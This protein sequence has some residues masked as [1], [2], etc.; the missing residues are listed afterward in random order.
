MNG[1]VRVKLPAAPEYGRMARTAAIQ[2]ARR[3]GFT[4]GD[5]SDLRLTMDAAVALLIDPD[6]SDGS[7]VFDYRGKAG[8][9]IIEAHIEREASTPIPHERI[10]RFEATA[11][12]LVDSWKL[13][14]DEN[15]LWLQKSGRNCS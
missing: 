15:Y 3:L 6:Q 13:D 2:I 4:T 5:I 10:D 8:I 12:S 11:G 14:P 1:D 9:V 7:I